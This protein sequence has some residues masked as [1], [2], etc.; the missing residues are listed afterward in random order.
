MSLLESITINSTA[1]T[2][3]IQSG[4]LMKQVT[5]AVS[6]SGFM[7]PFATGSAVGYVP[8]LLG[9]GNSPLVG[10][11]GMAVDSLLSARIVTAKEG[12]VTA[13]RDE[14]AELFWALK[15][16]GQFFGIVTEVTI[17]LFPLAKEIVS[18]TCIFVPTQIQEV[19]EA[20]KIV[21]DRVDAKS[22]GMAA[23]TV[24]PGPPG[25]TKVCFSLVVR[26]SRYYS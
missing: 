23:V 9:G 6:S 2:A 25:Q 3:T 19:A 18:W 17:K 26:I 14:N 15:G 16:A 13:S 5:K 4:V 22:S 10:M 24:P 11:C 1:A 12:L 7:T 8:F 21:V 20:L